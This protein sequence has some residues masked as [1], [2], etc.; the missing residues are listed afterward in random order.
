MKTFFDVNAILP[1]IKSIIKEINLALKKK[2]G[3][4]V[5]NGANKQFSN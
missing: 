4:P 1:I 2:Q 3:Q 5:K